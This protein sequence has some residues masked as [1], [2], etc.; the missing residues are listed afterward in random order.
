MSF[1]SYVLATLFILSLAQQA[2]CKTIWHWEDSFSEQEKQLLTRWV[3]EVVAAIESYSGSYPFDTHI[4]FHRK[5]DAKEPVPW[6]N[7]QRSEKQGVHFHVDTGYPLD[8]FRQDWT[9]AHELSH[10]LI[11]YLGRSLRWFAEGFASY[12]QYQIM[13]EMGL[14][15]EETLTSNYKDRLKKA[16][17]DYPMQNTPFTE[18]ADTLFKMRRYPVM[19]WGGASYFLLVDKKLKAQGTSMKNV[20]SDYLACCRMQKRSFNQLINL[21]DDLSGTNAFSQQLHIFKTKKGFPEYHTLFRQIT[22]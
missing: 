1:R 21:L 3:S 17:H 10:L 9:A 5:T 19:Y 12:M 22:K 4:Y 11:P 2:N 13:M 15:G 20:L 6:A 14:F 7:T 16:E 18:A 8:T